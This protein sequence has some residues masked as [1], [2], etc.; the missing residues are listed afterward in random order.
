VACAAAESSNHRFEELVMGVG[1]NAAKMDWN[2]NFTL[3]ACRQLDACRAF[4]SHVHRS[5]GLPLPAPA[6]RSPPFRVSFV[7]NK[8]FPDLEQLV[9]A[10]KSEARPGGDLDGFELNYVAWSPGK[11]RN[12]MQTGNFTRHMEIIAATDIHVSGGGTGQMYQTF[13]PDGAVHLALGENRE[14]TQGFMEEYMTEGA[15]YLKAL[16]YPRI[17]PHERFPEATVMK[18][19]LIRAKDMLVEGLD[20][21]VPVNNNLSPV[22]K[23]WKAYGFWALRDRIPGGV[24]ALASGTLANHEIVSEM[25]IGNSFPET[26]VYIGL[27]RYVDRKISISLPNKP[28]TCLLDGLRASFDRAFPEFGANGKGGWFGTGGRITP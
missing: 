1:L 12:D 25:H 7:Q 26:F 23:V 27:Q 4:R 10:L 5:Q 13:L 18:G 24:Q 21:P 6:R 22:G 2:V 3:G 8:R 20:G 15:P 28:E 19:L 16:Y 9:H 11:A 14:D 17:Q